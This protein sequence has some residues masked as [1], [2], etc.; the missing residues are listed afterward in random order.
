[1]EVRIN[2]RLVSMCKSYVNFGIISYLDKLFVH[3]L[4]YKLAV[5]T[6]GYNVTLH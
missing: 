2:E 6:S 5:A 3:K 1:M 4:L